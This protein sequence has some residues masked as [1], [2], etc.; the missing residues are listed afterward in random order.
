MLEAKKTR[1]HNSAK[2][3]ALEEV[4]KEKTKRLNVDIPAGLHTR[5]KMRAVEEGTSI[6]IIMAN[7][8]ESYLS[9]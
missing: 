5:L 3:D 8:L 9:K 4:I 2:E 1:R 6:R 7:L